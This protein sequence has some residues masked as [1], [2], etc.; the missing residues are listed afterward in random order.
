MS[1]CV[2]RWIIDRTQR[3]VTRNSLKLRCRANGVPC[4]PWDS[5]ADLRRRLDCAMMFGYPSEHADPRWLATLEGRM[6]ML[7]ARLMRAVGVA[8]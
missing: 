5:N 1:N 4:W 7:E 2:S 8:K 6:M 3:Y